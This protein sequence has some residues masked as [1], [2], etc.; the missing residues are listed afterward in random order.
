MIDDADLIIRLEGDP[1]QRQATIT[2]VRGS[3]LYRGGITTP[4]D[5]LQMPSHLRVRVATLID[6]T[7]LSPRPTPQLE[8]DQLWEWRPPPDWL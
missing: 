8:S 2:D 6:L 3:I 4:A 7:S 5:R 1:L